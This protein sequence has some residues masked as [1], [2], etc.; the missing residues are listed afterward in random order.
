MNP[1]QG[2]QWHA[3]PLNCYTTLLL[4]L[5]AATINL[6]QTRDCIAQ[7]NAD[8]FRTYHDGGDNETGTNSAWW[9]T[10][11]SIN[12]DPNRQPLNLMLEDVLFRT[13]QHSKQV[14]VFSE[15]PLI[16]ETAVTEAQ[17]AFDWTAF[18][19]S[20][21]EDLS[22][23]VG[24]SLTA[25]P[26]VNRFNDHN[27]TFGGGVRRRTM[28]GGQFEIAQRF[29][30]RD[31]NSEFFTPNDQGSSRLV[32]NFTQPLLRGRGKT[33]NRSLICLASIDQT[34]A[35]WELKRQLQDHLLE[36][37]RAYWALYFER[38]SLL[39]LNQS[40]LRA[41]QTVS[42]LENRRGLDLAEVMLKSAM[43]SANNREADLIRA[44]AAVKNAE[45]RLQALV[46]DP[47]M[48]SF[49]Q[50]EVIPM[51]R[52]S[53]DYVQTVDMHA[54]IQQAFTHRPEI[55]QELSRIKAASIRR[56]MSKQELLPVLN[57]VTEAYAAG[58]DSNRDIA[59]AFGNQFSEGDPGYSIGLQYEVPIHNRAARARYTRRRLE[60]RQLQNQ[61]ATM[62]ET[63]RLEVQVAVREQQTA[64]NEMHAKL[65]ALNAQ[66]AQLA[67]MERRFKLLP[68]ESDTAS[69]A[70]INLLDSQER[71]QKAES[72]YVQA[73]VTYSLS[74]MNLKRALG[75]LL[76]EEAI[77]VSRGCENALPT[78]F[79]N[80]SMPQTEYI[81]PGPIM[82]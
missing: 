6:V 50:I 9:E 63:V 29:G 15:L 51:A 7:H 55:I 31:N 39:Q 40:Y 36:V 77:S 74:Q 78:N 72:E 44:R 64:Y 25:G 80:K 42:T 57:L 21:W 45:A 41:T 73:Q 56:N 43:A 59:G 69:T 70:L 48:A 16:R 28:T 5:M 47:E 75:T 18:A 46:N 23:P 76:Q 11:T 79:Y 20:K 33:Y 8:S 67:A 3:V 19:E 66:T 82:Q 54:S 14:K 60:L 22:D 58:L 35:D 65:R 52:P 61:Y 1:I 24:N 49:D 38:A 81:S 13:L 2:K 30:L 17:A 53:N 71:V 12:L 34:A 26:G 4:I 32:L 68:G 10:Q 37:T 27:F 62:L